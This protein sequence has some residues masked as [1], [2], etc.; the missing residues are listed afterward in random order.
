MSKPGRNSPAWN[1]AVAFVKLPL[2]EIYHIEVPAG[3]GRDFIH[4][5]RVEI[6]KMRDIV[7]KRKYQLKPFKMVVIGIEPC[8]SVDTVKLM[9]RIALKKTLGADDMS[10][11]L[12]KILGDLTLGEQLTVSGSEG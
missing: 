2:E 7:R 9:E 1:H 5:I 3:E 8:G 10:E 12:Y 4:R 6:S 11:E